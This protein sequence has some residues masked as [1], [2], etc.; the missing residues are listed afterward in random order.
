VRRGYAVADK[1]ESITDIFWSAATADSDDRSPIPVVRHAL[2]CL[3]AFD[4]G[5]V[6]SPASGKPIQLGELLADVG[7]EEDLVYAS[8]EL[9]RGEAFDERSLVFTLGVLIFERFTGKHPFGTSDNSKRLARLRR[10][11]M[12]SGVN[13]IP[14]V[15][16]DM[17]AVLMRAMGPF[18]EERFG[19]L[20]EFRHALRRF[21]GLSQPSIRPVPKKGQP[22]FFDAPTRVAAHPQHDDQGRPLDPVSATSQQASADWLQPRREDETPVVTVPVGGPPQDR[23]AAPAQ[24]Q[25]S[26]GA[27]VTE[28]ELDNLFDELADKDDGSSAAVRQR[29]QRATD[30]VE[31]LPKP[32]L[33][34]TVGFDPPRI[35]DPRTPVLAGAPQ[36]SPLAKLMPLIYILAGAALASLVIFFFI[37]KE[38][39]TPSQQ[40]IAE[41]STPAEPKL[42]SEPTAPAEQPA[43]VPAE[44]PAPAE[45]P[46]PAP[47][48]KPTPAPAEKPTPVPAEQPAPVPAP[49]GSPVEASGQAVFAALQPCLPKK[50]PVLRVAIY[51]LPQG[52]VLRSFVAKKPGL[53]PKDIKCMRKNL[54]G[55]P[56]PLKLPKAGFVEWRFRSKDGQISIRLLRPKHLK[57]T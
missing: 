11:E 23:P 50:M 22:K 34:R 10:G 49:G 12:G 4:A 52:K 37:G 33:P 27:S 44:K 39:S 3:E 54:K 21:A 47:A 15:P 24:Q 2:N 41:G 26:G 28:Q 16:S 46:T 38:S 35:A 18:P 43:P 57:G 14:Q 1:Q 30:Q 40:R 25:L 6:K 42:P 36:R 5:L 7:M 13:Y 9:V 56:L 8:P 20:K 19:S 51:L 45:K 17:R 31:A 53:E 32:T 48:E 55:L 29:P